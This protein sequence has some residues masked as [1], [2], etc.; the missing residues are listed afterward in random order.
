MLRIDV[1][2]SLTDDAPASRLSPSNSL[3]DPSADK[4]RESLWLILSSVVFEHK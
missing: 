3:G 1:K 2:V 4:A